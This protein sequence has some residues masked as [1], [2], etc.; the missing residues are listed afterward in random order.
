MTLISLKSKPISGLCQ[1]YTGY[2][3]NKN[4]L[5]VAQN[6]NA[7]LGESSDSVLIGKEWRVIANL[8]VKINGLVCEGGELV[9]E[10]ELVGAVLGCCEGEA[11]VLLLHL[12]VECGAIWVLQTT[13]H[14]IMAASHNL[15][16][17]QQQTRHTFQ[18]QIIHRLL[19]PAFW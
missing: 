13:V 9:T 12:F 15:G 6:T 3:R 1:R 4:I 14:V 8:E 5:Y 17:Q 16:K 19:Y 18:S 7:H 11:V 2:S 10:A